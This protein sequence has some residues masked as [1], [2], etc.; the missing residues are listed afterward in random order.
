VLVNSVICP[1]FRCPFYRLLSQKLCCICFS[2][3]CYYWV[4]RL[5]QQLIVL[6]SVRIRYVE[7]RITLLTTNKLW[8]DSTYV[9]F[10]IFTKPWETRR[11][12]VCGGTMQQVGWSPARFPISLDSSINLSL[13]QH[14]GPGFGSASNRNDYQESSLGIKGGRRVRLTTSQ[15]F[16]SRLSTKCGILDVSQPYGPPRPVKKKNSMV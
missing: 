2:D 12:L 9:L 5:L 1:M 10:N 13:K 3:V 15:S 8:A 4:P 7:A 14:C 6:S 16:V 11:S